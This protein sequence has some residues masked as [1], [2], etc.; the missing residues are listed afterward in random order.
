M[1]AEDFCMTDAVIDK[2][3]SSGSRE[4]RREGRGNTFQKAKPSYE[5]LSTFAFRLSPWL[6]GRGLQPVWRSRGFLVRFV[7]PRIAA[8]LLQNDVSR[9]T[10]AR[11]TARTRAS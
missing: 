3:H 11:R 6:V 1:A 8:C 4:A 10:V 2:R 9:R 5:P 7:R